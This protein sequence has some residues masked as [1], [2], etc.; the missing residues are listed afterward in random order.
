MVEIVK[1]AISNK[2]VKNIPI[3]DLKVGMYIL[4][5]FSWFKHP[6]LKNHFKLRSQIEIAK[7]KELGFA[8]VQVD[9]SKSDLPENEKENPPEKLEINLP[10][11]WKPEEIVPP[12]LRQVLKSKTIPA[13]NK[14]AVVKNASLV[15]M[16]RLLEDP[17]AQNIKEA[18]QGIFDMV[19]CIIS[20]DDTSK[21]L[22]TITDH[23]LYT[24]THSVNVGL[25]A[26]LLAKNLFKG[27]YIHNMRELGA[28]F[29]LHDL[30]K[31]SIDPAII[32]KPGR[33]NEEEM[34]IVRKH[35]LNGA[36]ILE[37]SK[38]LSDEANIIVMQ[39]HER[40]DGSGY[41]QKLKGKEIHL[42]A[43]ICS[44]ADVY[45]ALTSERSYK[46]KLPPLEALKVMRDQMINHFQRDLFERFVMLFTK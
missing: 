33:L 4:L 8:D 20:D 24:Y 15:L 12:E 25:L 22:I 6:F 36:K 18:K 43:R 14:A 19:D 11:K 35:P 32:N 38:Q 44:I 41:P 29:F 27:S 1:N 42:Y 39:H 21:C 2:S 23:D 7:I 34:N 9:L 30:G 13:E 28:G 3:R 10:K 45:D 26:L 17:S 40:E 46:E 5:P 16:T 37:K 31:V